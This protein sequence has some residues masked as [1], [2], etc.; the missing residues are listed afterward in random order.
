MSVYQ[1]RVLNKTKNATFKSQITNNAA[2]VHSHS[3][4]H[5]HLG[6][7][8]LVP[9]DGEIQPHV[10]DA[11]EEQ[12]EEGGDEKERL[13]DHGAMGVCESKGYH[14]LTMQKGARLVL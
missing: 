14:Y 2:R 1:S 3:L 11:D 6:L 4:L 9:G 12:E 10:D 8:C 7:C 5:L 13:H